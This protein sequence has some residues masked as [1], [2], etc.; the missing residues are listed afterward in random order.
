[1]FSKMQSIIGKIQVN[2]K[3]RKHNAKNLFF[4]ILFYIGIKTNGN[5]I[6][7]IIL[8]CSKRRDAR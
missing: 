7:K 3:F 1:M 5:R 2:S 6:R 4:E 8:Y